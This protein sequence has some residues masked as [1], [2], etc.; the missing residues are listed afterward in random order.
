MSQELF[1]GLVVAF[2]MSGDVERR[3]GIRVLSAG[4]QSVTGCL[5]GKTKLYYNLLRYII[6]QCRVL[7]CGATYCIL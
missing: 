6:I 7:Q 3:K 1:W 2:G 4:S 5:Q